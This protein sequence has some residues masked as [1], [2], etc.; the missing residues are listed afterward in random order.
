MTQNTK[1]PSVRLGAYTWRDL[2]GSTTPG[3]ALRHN[4]HVAAHLTPAEAMQMADRLVDLAER[5]ERT[6]ALPLTDA[7]GSVEHELPTTVAE[8]E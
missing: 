6:P 2:D 8:L 4:K 3:I 5:V 1:R 7:S